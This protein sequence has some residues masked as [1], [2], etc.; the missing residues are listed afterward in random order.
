MRKYFIAVIIA[1]SVC[2]ILSADSQAGF[3]VDGYLH[4]DW[5]VRPGAYGSSDWAQN[6]GILG[7]EEDQKDTS[8]GYLN[9]GYGGQKFDSEAIYAT[10]SGG[11]IYLAIVTG[12]PQ[13]GWN[14]RKPGDVFINFG[15]GMQYGL[16]VRGADAGRLYKNPVW[17]TDPFWGTTTPTDMKNGAWTDKGFI[18]FV[19]F[20]T[21]H[22]SGTS[23][24]HW[25]MEIRI[26]ESFFG[27]DWM[28]G[29]YVSWTQTCANDVIR[30]DIPSTTP[31]PA[32]M[33]LLGAGI[34]GIISSRRR[35]GK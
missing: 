29:G 19:Y 16:S 34:I 31:E 24:D 15:T 27:T 2:T 7:Y 22:G 28:N 1:V 18:E 4:D 13:D 12:H 6:G 10:R 23:N 30:L 11:N 8:N 17:N 9:P 21:Y 20:H 32:S 26:P 14:T 25:V 5:G 3:V 35:F 33:A